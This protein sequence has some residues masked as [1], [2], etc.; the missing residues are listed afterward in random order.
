MSI[1]APTSAAQLAPAGD[2]GLAAATATY[3]EG[4]AERDAGNFVAAAESFTEAYA[5]I[6]MQSREIRSA[7][8][9]DLVDARRQAFALGE[10]P[11][12]ICECE[13]LLGSYLADV[14]QTF[15]SKG[16]KFPDTRKAKKL[17]VE[18]RKQLTKQMLE[19]PELDCAATTVARPPEPEPVP[20][21]PPLPPEPTGP[22]E[23]Q[24]QAQAAR[25]RRARTQVI[26]GAVTTGVGGLFLGVMAA[27]LVVGRRAE[28]AGTTATQEG[29]ASGQPLSE[30]DPELR[31]IVARGKL[32]NGL[33]IAGGVLA[34]VAV[35]AGVSLL[36]LGL[37]AR[38]E[39]PRAAVAPALAP[40]FVGAGVV[41]RF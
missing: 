14:K 24:L 32:G 33:A 36:V 4:I 1:A 41:L 10:G 20:E 13:R 23:A 35:A 19:T 27:G 37:R 29:L 22:S 3:N 21:P 38:K 17:L 28:Q 7:V 8:L 12:Q 39:P 6:P 15:G 30:D 40:G 16:D 26:A 11:A 18:V 31:D 9:F 2:D 34:T 5:A 25:D